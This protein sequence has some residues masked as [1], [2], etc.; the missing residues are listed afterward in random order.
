MAG[1]IP[2]L[3]SSVIM[4]GYWFGNLVVVL[5]FLHFVIQSTRNRTSFYPARKVA[6][7]FKYLAANI[8]VMAIA[9]LCGLF[10]SLPAIGVYFSGVLEN[11]DTQTL[12]IILMIPSVVLALFGILIPFLRF[13]FVCPAIAVGDSFNFHTVWAMTKG[14]SFR[15]VFFFLFL[16]FVVMAF[17]I[18]LSMVL[19]E[20]TR[21]YVGIISV[22][23]VFWSVWVYAFE[24]LLYEDLRLRYEAMKS[25]ASS[26]HAG[27]DAVEQGGAHATHDIQ[28]L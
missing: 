20:M 3:I 22:F 9:V 15:I 24:S 28:H 14:H 5:S 27:K 1:S 16:V 6:T 17:S 8:A 4:V 10:A 12:G 18:G 7:S 21:T 11:P 23:T 2:P 26:F 13:S 19:G 25:G